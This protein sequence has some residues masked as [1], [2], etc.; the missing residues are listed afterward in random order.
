MF[1]IRAKGPFVL[2]LSRKIHLLQSMLAKSLIRIPKLLKKGNSFI[3]IALI[4][5]YANFQSVIS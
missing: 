3:E 5:I 2:I 4:V 1:L